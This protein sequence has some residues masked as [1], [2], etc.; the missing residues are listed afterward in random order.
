MIIDESWQ[1]SGVIS[2]F[3][4]LICLVDGVIQDTAKPAGIALQFAEHN[5]LTSSLIS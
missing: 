2:L 4:Y 1:L 3:H 5:P